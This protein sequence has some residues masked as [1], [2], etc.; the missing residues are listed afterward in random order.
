MFSDL[1]PFFQE[2]A[3]ECLLDG[4]VVRCI[5]DNGYANAL[6]MMA[7][8]DPALQ[9]PTSAI[10]PDL[11]DKPAVVRG[12]AYHVKA[13]RPDGTGVTFLDLERD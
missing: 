3:E 1:T 2:F 8:T 5:F 4:V 11:R 7:G 10:G 6:G 9:C 13:V 12:V